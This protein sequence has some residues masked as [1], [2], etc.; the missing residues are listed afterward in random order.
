MSEIQKTLEQALSQP[1]YHY[2]VVFLDLDNFKLV[3]DSLGHTIGDELLVQVSERL[4]NCVRSGDLV[5]RLGGDEFIILL[6]SISDEEDAFQVAQRVLDEMRLPLEIHGNRIVCSVSIGI[7]LDDSEELAEGNLRDADIAMYQAKMKGK[8]RYELFEPEMR[9]QAVERLKLENDLRNALQRQEFALYYQPIVSLADQTIFGFET[10]L[11]W[12]HPER[13]TLGPVEFISVL[14]ETGLIVPLGKW[15]LM[16]ACNRA[17]SWS[18][19]HSQGPVVSVNISVRQLAHPDFIHHVQA[20]LSSSKLAPE[21]LALEITESALMENIELASEVLETLSRIGVQTHI[22]DFGT[23]YSSLGRLQN[24]PITTIK[25]A[26][27][28]VSAISPLSDNQDL[29]RAITVLSQEL[30]LSTIA[31]GIENEY[32][33]EYLLNLGCPMGQG[34]YFSEPVPAEGVARIIRRFFPSQ[35]FILAPPLPAHRSV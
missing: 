33:F 28:F 26:N 35:K 23:G 7:V 8:N 6:R 1:D 3:N 34:F 19:N 14:E 15:I 27:S 25:I 12:Q 9:L 30:R 21:R 2:A 4:K 11:R 29:V 32:Q 10:L 16:E 24:L 18:N 5:G 22:D 31:E 17:V 13:G 20:A